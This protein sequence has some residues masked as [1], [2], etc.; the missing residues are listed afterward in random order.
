MDY[1]ADDPQYVYP[2]W[3]MKRDPQVVD[4]AADGEKVWY[5]TFGANMNANTLSSRGV[6][7]SQSIA[8]SLPGYRLA[9]TYAGYEGCEPRFA[10]IEVREACRE[11]FAATFDCDVQGVAHCI[12]L[13]ELQLLD[14][15]EGCG[16]A[17]M[18]FTTTF[19]A[20]GVEGPGRNVYA[21]TALESHRTCPG[22]P[23]KRYLHLLV[24]G[25]IGSGLSPDYVNNL[26][27]IPCFD[28]S[29]HA[30]PHV[31]GAIADTNISIPSS[32]AALHSYDAVLKTNTGKVVPAEKMGVWASIG[33]MVFD[34][35]SQVESRAML[36]GIS[37]AIDGTGFVLQ[38]W[39][40]AYT[41]GI[42]EA[43]DK[44][45]KGNEEKNTAPQAVIDIA[46]LDEERRAYVS[47]WAQ[48]LAATFPFVGTLETK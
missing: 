32:T 39:A 45:K 29:G 41:N 36:R 21:Y 4:K 23:S 19:K 1:P 5:F 27:L 8:G 9:F 14:S 24:E 10:N 13:A 26:R 34:V 15:F 30:M 16:V 6:Y 44:E 42:V 43:S 35:S 40:N 48:H 46:A 25:A 18:R 3:L 11:D 47:S 22:L 38:L 7:P 2:V 31:S 20:S 37:N 12:T 28:C 17:Y 33:G